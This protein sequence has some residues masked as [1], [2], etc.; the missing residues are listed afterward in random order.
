MSE[1]E[2]L[3]L[4]DGNKVASVEKYKFEPIKGYPM[5]NWHGKRPFTSTQYYP[6]QKKEVYGAEE[7]A[8]I[9]K[10]FWGD[11]VQV[12]SHLL[13]DYRGKIKLIYIDPPFDSN[14]DY[15]KR[16]TL[17]GKQVTNDQTNFEEKQYTDIWSNDEYLQFMYE[18]IILLR[19]I[20]SENGTIW[21]HCDYRKSHQLKCIMDEV[22]G[23]NNHVSDVIWKRA[24]ARGNVKRGFSVAHDNLLVYCKSVDHTWTPP[25]LEYSEEYISRFNQIDEDGRRYTLDNMISPN[26]DRP[27]LDYEWNGVRKV[28]RVTKEKMAEMDRNG[29]IGYTSN[30]VAR[31][32]RYLDA[33]GGQPLTTI[34]DDIDPVNSQ[35]VERENYPTQK[36]MKLLDRIIMTSTEE[37]DLVFDCFMGSGT[38]QVAAYKANRKFIGADINLG[39]IQTTT[40]RLVSII[41][42]TNESQSE[43]V[44]G[45]NCGFEVFNVNN[46]DIFRNPVEA[47]G[48]LL[49][50]LEIDELTGSTYD[51]EKDGYMV[52]VMPVNR[53]A[54]REDLNEL[55][56][57]FPYKVFEQRKEDN[58]TKP[59][60][61][62]MLICMG[63]E[64]DLKAHLEQECGYKLNVDVIDILR[65]KSNIEF[66]RDSEAS[67]EIVDE[68][69]KILSF[70]PMNLM[71]KLSLQK[72]SVSEWRELVESIVIDWNYGYAN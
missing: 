8:W 42:S 18:R 70:Y 4:N 20:L 17:K 22:F 62:V 43:P 51:G 69:F 53:I 28:W 31:F 36:P 6:A 57:N 27:N 46:Y 40:K 48:L 14:A 72:E 21:L 5:L 38:T 32:K 11:N 58:P 15:K 25:K 56:S 45:A 61:S 44:H 7:D 60:E 47:K 64:P 71:Q 29:Q 13:K 67:I 30:G 52:K 2:S 59:V 12:M 24:A 1:Q 41:Q 33:L 23:N 26:P 39:A 54:T 49:E 9:N 34:W 55:I 66:K 37:G 50:A 16:I 3:N 68:Q 35:A 19:E 10:I 65:D 63:H